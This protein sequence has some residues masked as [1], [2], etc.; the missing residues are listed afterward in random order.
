MTQGAREAARPK[1]RRL[2]RSRAIDAPT[3]S[4]GR[5]R[6]SSRRR[7]A[8]RSPCSASHEVGG[9]AR[10]PRLRRRRRDASRPTR[11]DGKPVGT[12]ARRHDAGFFEGRLTLEDA[13]AAPIPRRAMPAATGR[14]SIPI[15]S[16]RC[17]ARWT[18]TISARAR[19]SASS[20]SWARILIDHEGVDGVHFAVWAPNAAPRLGGRRLQRLGRPPPRRCGGAATPASGRSSCPASREG[21]L[22]KY[23]IVG[24]RRRRCCRSRP[25]RSASAAELPPETASRRRRHRAASAGT[26]T[27]AWR[28]GAERRRRAARRSRSTRC[29]SAPGSAARATRF[30]TWDELADRLIPYAV[31]MGFTHI[32]FLPISE[33]P[34]DASWGYQPIGLFAPTARFGDARRL[35]PLRR[36]R[37]PGRPRRPPRLGAGAFP[38]RRARPRAASTAPRSTSTPTRA[39]ASTRTGTPRSTIS[40]G[41]EVVNF[42]VNNAL[43]WLESSTSTGCAS[44]PSPRCSTSTIRARRASGCPTQYGGRENLEAIALP[45]G[46]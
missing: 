44:M 46:A 5:S 13:P 12:L 25:I 31:D 36:R 3:R 38:D 23:E 21:A 34:F 41:S 42:L 15:P 26:T 1:G 40:A 24:P 19:I 6:R 17:S 39:R 18:T 2:R 4:G 35:R 7:T 30:L 8:I 20:T 29:I 22:Y 16:V 32:E 11:S 27:T 28:L 14:S 37:P 9:Q 43:Y 33:H 45:A 10:R